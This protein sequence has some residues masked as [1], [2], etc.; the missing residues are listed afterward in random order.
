VLLADD[1]LSVRRLAQHLLQ[2]SGY[3]V[4]TAED[5]LQALHTL[6]TAK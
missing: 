5:G 2:S 6:E 3:R 4:E 1:S